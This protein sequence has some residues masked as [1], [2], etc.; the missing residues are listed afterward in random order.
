MSIGAAPVG[1]DHGAE[2][3]AP[4]G[5]GGGHER[6]HAERRRAPTRRAASAACG[7]S[8]SK[9]STA[10]SSPIPNGRSRPRSS[11]ASSRPL[12]ASASRSPASR[13]SVSR[14]TR[15]RISSSPT[16][17]AACREIRRSKSPS[18]PLSETTTS[19][20]TGEASRRP[21]TGTARARSIELAGRRGEAGDLA[22]A[23]A[24]L[25][26]LGR[27]RARR[28]PRVGP[29]PGRA[30]QLGARLASRTIA[31]PPIA[32]AIDSRI[33]VEAAALDAPAARAARAPGRRA[34]ARR[35]A[36]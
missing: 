28:P 3:R 23:L 31:A 9:T 34:R 11:S 7:S 20:A 24:V 16:T 2:Q 6:R 18:G 26:D 10:A 33:C 12:S 14:T 13:R 29:A 27:D 4:G 22:R 30:G 8:S 17:I 19:Q 5:G 32:A 36:R 15:S 21:E 35:T 25:G 1:A